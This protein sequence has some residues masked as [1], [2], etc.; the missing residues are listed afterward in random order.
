MEIKFGNKFI[1]DN[2]PA[3][4]VAEMS[5][6]HDGDINKAL[7][8]IHIAKD[9]G[10][11]AIK[12]Q[13]YSA[14]SLTLK[15]KN[16]DFNLANDSPWASYKNLWNL[17]NKGSTPYDWHEDLFKEARSIDL[18][19]FSTP[20]D[21]FGVDF[22][23]DLNVPVFKIASPEIN[24]LPLI[25]KACKTG[26]PIIL[27]TGVADL[28]DI[29]LAIKTIRKNQSNADI[30]LLQCNSSYPTP[31]EDSNLLTLKDFKSRFNVLTGFSDH[32]KGLHCAIAS[33][34]LGA[35][36][37]EKHFCIKGHESVDS[38]F[39]IYPEDFKQ[40]VSNIRDVEL[41]LGKVS[42]DISDSA[43]QSMNG[44]RSIYVSK[45]IRKGELVTEMNVKCVRPSH[46]LHPKHYEKI[47]GKHSKKNL[48]K[49][50]RIKLDYFE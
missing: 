31:Y 27:S 42:Y 47:I 29:T 5:A 23:M 50:D 35:N 6:N 49:G 39:S 38:F 25:I 28:E 17:Y 7:E 4:I 36:L 9:M 18:E 14:D 43:Q 21:E 13:T 30:I 20:F 37:I 2:H 10:A 24:H 34:C 3:F 33:V 15:I 48:K 22:L 45:D 1:G 11:D 8:M 32:T 12:L 16:K 44:R 40:M 26:K 46:S 41:A 19:I